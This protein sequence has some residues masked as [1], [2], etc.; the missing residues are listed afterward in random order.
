MRGGIR[1]S[2]LM[3]D[4]AYDG[5]PSS[6]FAMDKAITHTTRCL[7]LS[8]AAVEQFSGQPIEDKNKELKGDL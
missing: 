5:S 4:K 2:S 3:P 6:P 8:Y 1:A 7:S